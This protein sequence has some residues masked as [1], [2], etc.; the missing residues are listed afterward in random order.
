M[1][2]ADSTS[3][4]QHGADRRRPPGLLL[5]AGAYLVA[6]GAAPL[7]V[8]RTLSDLDNFLWP[9][10]RL[11]AHGQALHIFALTPGGSAHADDNG[12]LDRLPLTPIALVANALGIQNDLRLRAA[13]VLTGTSIFSLLLGARDLACRVGD[14]RGARAAPGR[15]GSDPADTAALDLGA[16][17]RPRRS[18]SRALARPV[19]RSASRAQA[20]GACRDP[21]RSGGAHAAGL[22]DLAE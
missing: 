13:L 1:T 12:P 14:A 10:A 7:V 3:D 5:L 4:V 20:G 11:A 22:E 17:L 16:R 9:S 8:G 6:L 19:E 2:G 18:A 15:G 21:V